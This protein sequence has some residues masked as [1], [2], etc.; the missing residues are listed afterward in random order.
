MTL[1]SITTYIYI[2]IYMFVCGNCDRN[3]MV[4]IVQYSKKMDKLIVLR[5]SD[6]NCT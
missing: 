4:S 5:E 6:L 2:Y 3:P 1:L